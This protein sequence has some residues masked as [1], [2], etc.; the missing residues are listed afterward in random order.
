MIRSYRDLKMWQA[1]MDLVEQIYGLTRQFPRYEIYGLSQ[2]ARRAALSVPSNIAEGHARQSTKEYLQ[3]V[4]IALGSLAE[5]ETQL[6]AAV[7]LGYADAADA[8]P[9]LVLAQSVGKMLRAL[10]K[11]LRSHLSPAVRSLPPIPDP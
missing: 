3:H 10:Q 5:T 9:A 8:E 2:Q 6:L 11:S 4:S 1:G 7:R